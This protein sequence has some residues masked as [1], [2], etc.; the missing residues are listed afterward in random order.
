MSYL[1]IFLLF[2]YSIESWVQVFNST[3]DPI[4]GKV[5]YPSFGVS[6]NNIFIYGG[7]SD[8]SSIDASKGIVLKSF[9]SSILKYT[10]V[11]IELENKI[12][13]KSSFV[14]IEGKGPLVSYHFGGFEDDHLTNQIQVVKCSIVDNNCTVQ[15]IKP[16]QN[17]PSGRYGSVL[18][19]YNNK[20]YLFGGKNEN[21][22][23]DDDIYEYDI[24]SDKWNKI[25]ILNNGAKP[26]CRY[27]ASGSVYVDSNDN[28]KDYLIIY[29]GINIENDKDYYSDVWKY[30][31][32]EKN[33]KEI[34]IIGPK[35]KRAFHSVNFIGKKLIVHGGYKI[36]DKVNTISGDTLVLELN[37]N[38]NNDL[39]WKLVDK[40]NL[41]RYKHSSII[42]NNYVLITGGKNEDN[43][44]VEGLYMLNYDSSISLS[45]YN[46][47]LLFIYIE[48][49]PYE[50]IPEINPLMYIALVFPIIISVII[51][52]I[53][54]LASYREGMII[55]N[56]YIYI[57]IYIISSNKQWKEWEYV[58][59]FLN[60]Y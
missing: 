13:N 53:L 60:Q 27:Y 57:F 17:I 15:T 48:T 12:H 34:K 28:T 33:W 50:N 16:S 4:F 35:L 39:E 26:S 37:D 36:G 58:Q 6:D 22:D 19:F 14:N 5:D 23:C 43:K 25:E 41:P 20:L 3:T 10:A 55:T 32:I 49:P 1:L 31:F 44:N 9:N 30:S 42:L 51:P 8:N 18:L 56:V 54:C 45:I 2:E 7:I 11:S 29:G 24:K 47:L 21:S 59:E 52:L 46:Y 40:I 38:N